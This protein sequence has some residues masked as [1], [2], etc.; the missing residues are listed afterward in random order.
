MHLQLY[1]SP[2]SSMSLSTILDMMAPPMGM[3]AH[4]LYA[5]EEHSTGHMSPCQVQTQSFRTQPIQKVHWFN[6]PQSLLY[7]YIKL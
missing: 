3:P 7:Q 4:L 2:A 5:S 6:T 1:I